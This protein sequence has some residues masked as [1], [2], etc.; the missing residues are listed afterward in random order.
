[1]NL[2]LFSPTATSRVDAGREIVSTYSYCIFIVFGE[3]FTEVQNNIPNGWTE[4]SYWITAAGSATYARSNAIW[5]SVKERDA[6]TGDV[7]IL[8]YNVTL[9]LYELNL[10]YPDMNLRLSNGDTVYENTSGTSAGNPT[11]TNAHNLTYEDDA[12]DAVYHYVLEATFYYDETQRHINYKDAGGADFSG[13]HASGYSTTHKIGETTTLDTPT[14]TNYTF[15]GY[16]L[17]DPTCAAS[18]LVTTL[19]AATEYETITLYAKWEPVVITITLTCSN[20]SE[21]APN[22]MMYIYKNDT[23]TCQVVPT[24]A[25]Y[26]L[27]VLAP[28]LAT[29]DTYTVAFVFGYYGQFSATPTS[30]VEVN[31]RKLKITSITNKTITYTLVTPRI[32]STVI[33]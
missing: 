32:N 25:T 19:S 33:I 30:G 18:N 23:L 10:L 13:T 9:P 16:Y 20:Y 17:N 27:K 26:Q 6:T 11:I 14:K 5:I 3:E 8:K 29:G 7:S 21:A 4:A 2:N 31:G 22:Y 12:Y 15:A 24:S 28:E 1:M